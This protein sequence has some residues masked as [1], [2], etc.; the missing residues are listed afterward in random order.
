MTVPTPF[1]QIASMRAVTPL[2]EGRGIHPDTRPLP[3][4]ICHSF[5]VRRVQLW[6]AR[7][8][9]AFAGLVIH[10]CVVSL[11]GVSSYGDGDMP[12][13]PDSAARWL[14]ARKP[15]HDGGVVLV[16]AAVVLVLVVEAE[17]KVVCV[18]EGGHVVVEFRVHGPFLDWHRLRRRLSF[19]SWLMLLRLCG[20]GGMLGGLGMSCG[21]LVV[22]CQGLVAVEMA[23]AT[24]TVELA[25]L[26]RG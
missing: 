21:V 1:T 18:E 9:A 26:V 4:P 6:F 10:P 15:A 5:S 17:E 8:P 7:P 16:D 14:A 3:E 22:L 2:R 20:T 23:I 24:C 25:R 12:G 13:C 19:R 11:V